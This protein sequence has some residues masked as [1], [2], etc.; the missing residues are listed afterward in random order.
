MAHV[1][2]NQQ[3]SLRHFPPII[4]CR[5][6]HVIPCELH[7]GGTYYIDFAAADLTLVRYKR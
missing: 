1:Y 5:L 2:S 4:K 6:P 7:D 3:K